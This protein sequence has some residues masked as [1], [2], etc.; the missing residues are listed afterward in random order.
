M[1]IAVLAAALTVVAL[2]QPF[3]MTAGL[4][5]D[6]IIM[7]NYLKEQTIQLYRE[8]GQKQTGKH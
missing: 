7:E 2:S 4:N 5:L 6:T 3:F 8:L 1:E